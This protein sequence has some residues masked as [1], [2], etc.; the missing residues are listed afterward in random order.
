MKTLTII[1]RIVL[2]LLLISPILG[3]LG[4]FPPPT[5]D[6]YN[7]AEGFAYIQMLFQVGYV[8]WIMAIV[9]AVSIVLIVMNRMAL[10]ALLILP[11]T[12]NI[13]GFHAFVDGGLFTAGAMMANALALINLFF[14]WRNRA[15]YR[16]LL[17]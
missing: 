6:M 13:I 7:T 17:A 12:V 15:A 8:V 14:L 1:L 3:A 4:V 16:N 11:I 2:A 9:F 10:V 5:A